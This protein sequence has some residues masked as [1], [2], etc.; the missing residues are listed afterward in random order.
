M[1]KYINTPSS[2]SLKDI[3]DKDYQMSS[4]SYRCLQMPNSNYK[5]LR[6]FLSRPLSRKDL[7]VEVGAL[8]YIEKSP[9]KFI[10]AKALQEHSYLLDLSGETVMNILPSDFIQMNLKKGDILISKDS[11]IGEV[12]ILDKDYPNYMLSSAIYK[13]PVLEEWKYYVLAIL[14]HQL[15]REQLDYM[16]PKGATI[17]HAKKLFLDCKIPLPVENEEKTCA[18]INSLMRAITVKEIQI[19]YRY[20]KILSLIDKELMSNQNDNQFNY[21]LPSYNDIMQ[22]NRLDTNMY[23]SYFKKELFYIENYKYGTKA[24]EDLGFTLSRGQNLQISNI[25]ISIYSKDR[26]DNFYTLML[27]K[28]LSKYGTINE[29]SYL[30]NKNKLKQLKCGDIIFGAEGFEKGRSIVVIEENAN[31]ITNIHGITIQQKGDDLTKAIFVKCFLDYL[32]SKGL[33]D[34]F[35]VGGNGG[36]LAQKYWSYIPFPIFPESKQKEIAFQYH[37]PID[38]PANTISSDIFDEMESVFNETAGIYELDCSVKYLQSLL[39]KAIDN[40][41]YGKRMSWDTGVTD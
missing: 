26:H 22:L 31:T 37:N 25:G 3:V 24:I 27:P 13:L 11:N 16:V 4:S 6:D 2:V 23:R 28:Y 15:F 35:A 8:S 36:S 5:L 14:K 10:R 41:V 9:Y 7:G 12:V 19:K 40:L 17:R 39:D 34:L 38:Y 33:I 18:Y 1:D 30:G 21:S 32:R 29:I 20:E